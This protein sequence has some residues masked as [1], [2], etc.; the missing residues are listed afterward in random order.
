MVRAVI[1]CIFEVMRPVDVVGKKVL[2]SP[3]NWGFGHVS[4][5]IALIDQLLQQGNNVI[6]ACEGAQQEVYKEYFPDLNYE[7]HEGYPFDFKGKG[8][9]AWDLFL[10]GSK[11][12][13][14]LNSETRQVSRLV[15]KH[16][17][18]LILSDH[19]YGF[20]L[21]GMHSVF[22]THQYNL[23]VKWFQA[24]VDILHKKLMK[25]FH[26]I[27]VMDD[28]NSRL[29][30]KL[31]VSMDAKSVAYIGAYSR[32]SLYQEFPEKSVEKL[33]IISGPEI[34]AQQFADWVVKEHPDAT[35]VCDKSISTPQNTV[36]F[37]GSWRHRDDQILK[38]K[39][40][41]SRSG[42][43]TIMDADF[44]GIPI[45]LVP[46]PGQAEQVYLSKWFKGSD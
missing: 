7:F 36:R 40:L 9:F 46:T 25:R 31:S 33:A 23:P 32:F 10:R 44:L 18:D 3:L 21:K 17:V 45:T 13:L 6:I 19:R 16:Q 43:S 20:Y 24:P 39:H 12:R 29:A 42:Y 28:S 4:R 34:Y 1:P 27:W 41:I 15:K 11:L 8:N 14:R 30:G 38:A 22:I 5:S 2:F 35:L 26:Q 37:S